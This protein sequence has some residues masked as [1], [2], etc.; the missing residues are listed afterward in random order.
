MFQWRLP[1]TVKN[2]DG[3]PNEFRAAISEIRNRGRNIAAFRLK[4]SRMAYFGPP[5]RSRNRDVKI[6]GEMWQKI[7]CR[8]WN[9]GLKSDTPAASLTPHIL[10]QNRRPNLYFGSKSRLEIWYPRSQS[11]TSYFGSKSRTKPIFW[12][13]IGAWNLISPQPVSHLIFWVNKN[14]FI[15]F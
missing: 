1:F 3:F 12:V 14:Q 8:E 7:K 6:S 13:E 15:E 5:L 2:D 10:G 4:I 11:H 9:R